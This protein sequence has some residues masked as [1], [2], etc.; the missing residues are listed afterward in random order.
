MNSRN[1]VFE[2]LF[3]AIISSLFCFLLSLRPVPSVDHPNDTGRY[4]HY[5]HEYCGGF[6]DQQNEDKELSFSF[7]YSFTSAACVVKSDSVFLFQVAILLPLFF[8]IFSKWRNG[9]FLW[10]LTLLLSMFGIELMTNAMRQSFGTLLFF[11]AIATLR[12]HRLLALC[13]GILAVIAHNSTLTYSPLLLW[14]VD[15]HFSKKVIQRIAAVLVIIF[16]GLFGIFYSDILNFID[17]A[18]ELNK[19]YSTIYVDELSLSFLLYVIL[20]LYWIYGVRYFRDRD[21]ITIEEKKGII[22]STALLIISYL[23]FPAITYR[24]AI[25]AVVLQLFLVTRSE[26]QGAVSACYVLIPLIVHLTLMIF[27]SN[28]Y[29]VLLYG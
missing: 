20:P 8:L 22:Y 26:K 29:L 7:F 18:F 4:V 2:W 6:I 27:I 15:L 5:L 21:H 17:A 16:I 3:F 9:T 28:N 25:F 24:Y 13:F 1:R 14:L 11:G 19:F 12:R 23:F 10:A